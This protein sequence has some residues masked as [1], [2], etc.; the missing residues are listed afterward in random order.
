MRKVV[1]KIN[2]IL[3]R[4]RDN[5]PHFHEHRHQVQFGLNIWIGVVCNT[6]MGPS[7]LPKRQTAQ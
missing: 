6:L 7:L 1:F 5:P 2:N 4:A 3:I